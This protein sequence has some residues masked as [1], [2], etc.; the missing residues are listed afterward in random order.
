MPKGKSKKEE[1]DKPSQKNTPKKLILC[2]LV[3]AY[4]EEN[5][6]IKGALNS[7]GLLEQYHHELEVYGYGDI[8]P[9]ITV[10]ELSEIINEFLGE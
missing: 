8:K 10:D 6:V 1:T 3:E 4:P 9:S 7:A 5:W 2:E